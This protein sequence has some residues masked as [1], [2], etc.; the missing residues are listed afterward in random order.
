MT[1]FH[2]RDMVSGKVKGIRCEDVKVFQAPQY[3]GLKTELM[4]KWADSYPDVAKYLPL[5]PRETEKL[6]R[7]YVS[8]VIYTVV[9]EPF[10]D[11][12]VS[13]INDRN[14]K[15]E[16]SQDMTVHMD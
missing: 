14:S 9:G 1:I 8:T 6:H 13:K 11:W 16:E 10:S 4:L 3:S 5:E 2:L 12:V 7:D 15:V